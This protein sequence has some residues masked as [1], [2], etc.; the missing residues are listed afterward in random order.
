MQEF[1]QTKTDHNIFVSLSKYPIIR[2]YVDNLF[3]VGES[4]QK[5][6]YQPQKIITNHFKMTDLGPVTHYVRLCIIRDIIVGIMF[7]F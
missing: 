7:F 2:I 5:E 4:S 6:N 1:I 3:T